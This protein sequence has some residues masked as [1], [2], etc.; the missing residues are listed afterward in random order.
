MLHVLPAARLA[1]CFFAEKKVS[2]DA[3]TS[4]A[5][6]RPPPATSLRDSLLHAPHVPHVCQVHRVVTIIIN[7]IAATASG[8]AAVA[9]IIIERESVDVT[10]RA[11]SA[12]RQGR[13]SEAPKWIGRR[14]DVAV[15]R[16]LLVLR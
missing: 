9:V 2:V 11:V 4:R 10:P 6:L 1:R 14:T 12:L 16:L 5:R 3:P 8:V 13:D 7:V 15:C